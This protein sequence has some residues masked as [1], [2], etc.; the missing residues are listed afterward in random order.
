MQSD[1]VPYNHDD[2]WA[3]RDLVVKVPQLYRRQFSHATVRAAMDAFFVPTEPN[4]VRERVPPGNGVHELYAALKVLQRST[5][6][7][8]EMYL[9]S[10]ECRGRIADVLFAM[11]HLQADSEAQLEPEWVPSIRV[12]LSVD[13][14]VLLDWL[15]RM[16]NIDPQGSADSTMNLR[17]VDRAFSFYGTLARGRPA[18]A[19]AAPGV[20]APV[21]PA[22]VKPPQPQA[23]TIRGDCTGVGCPP[24]VAVSPNPDAITHRLIKYVTRTIIKK[25]LASSSTTPTA[26]TREELQ[27]VLGGAGAKG[28][29]N[30][31]L[32]QAE[33]KQ[34]QRELL[35]FLISV[36]PVSS[37]ELP[38]LKDMLKKKA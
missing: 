35:Q 32:K 3:G 38:E 24:P 6:E 36:V 28:I 33:T 27:A 37:K 25:D 26:P 14:Q 29:L 13:G 2:Y 8:I 31:L 20:T 23:T 4:G 18:T 21:V 9:P 11:V 34:Q 5:R 19:A 10:R 7:P 16:L 15:P 17:M 12:A 22:F 1:D 30:H